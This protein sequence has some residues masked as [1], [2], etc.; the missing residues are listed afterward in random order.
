MALN[1]GSQLIKVEVTYHSQSQFPNFISL[2]GGVRPCP[3]LLPVPG[4]RS[5]LGKRQP[6]LSFSLWSTWGA[7]IQEDGAKVTFMFA[8]S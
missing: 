2:E 6:L 8:F 1:P 5:A 3:V 4:T 7:P